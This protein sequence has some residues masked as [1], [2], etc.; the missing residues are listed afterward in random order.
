MSFTNLFSKLTAHQKQFITNELKNLI[1]ICDNQ[2]K[3][4][5]EINHILNNIFQDCVKEEV[6]RQL[7]ID[8]THEFL[9]KNSKQISEM[10]KSKQ[11]FIGNSTIEKYMSVTLVN[12][13]SSET[14]EDIKLQDKVLKQ[15]LDE[16][17]KQLSTN[18]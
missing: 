15:T 4:Q 14:L 7:T 18:K 1:N 12:V 16:I 9:T 10:L 5:S 3:K 2:M 17:F 8:E 6:G 11:L 13:G